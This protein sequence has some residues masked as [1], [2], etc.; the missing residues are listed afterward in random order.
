MATL[1]VLTIFVMEAISHKVE[2]GSGTGD[3]E[4]QVK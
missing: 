2:S 3:D 1:V 4:L